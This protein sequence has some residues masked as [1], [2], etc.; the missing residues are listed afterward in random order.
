ME[1]MNQPIEINKKEAK[2][3]KINQMENLYLNTITKII[4]ILKRFNCRLKKNQ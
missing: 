3:T 4:N 1:T 2:I